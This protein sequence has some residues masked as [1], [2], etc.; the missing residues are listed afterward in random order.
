[1][2][3]LLARVK[4]TQPLRAWTRFGNVRGNLLASGIAFY[5]FF[6]IFPA[7]AIAAVIFGFVLRGHPE[8]IASVGHSLNQTLPNF[9]KTADNPD[10]L[11]ELKA[12]AVSALTI[13]GLVAV[14]GLVLSG[15]GWVG[16]MRDGIRAVFGVAGSPG[17]LITD[18]L[19]DLG[20]LVSLGAGVLVSG[21]L[22]SLLGSGA[23]GLSERVGLG[24]S[25]V[26]VTVVG[27]VVGF[28][29]DVAVMVL[30]LRVLS[31]VPLPWQDV[32]EGALV[33]GIGLSVIKIFGVQL[34]GNATK[35]PLFGSIV[36]VIGLLF[37][38]NLIAKIILLAASW[39]AN[40]IDEHLARLET[41]I[42]SSVTDDEVLEYQ[43][44]TQSSAGR[45]QSSAG[46]PE[47][48]AG[49]PRPGPGRAQ[50]VPG[51]A[52]RLTAAGG[53]AVPT[54]SGAAQR[55]GEVDLCDDRSRAVSGIPAFGPRT[56]D[57]ASIAAGA[58]LGATAAI[59]L[60]S[61]GRTIRS[62]LTRR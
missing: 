29:V 53:G 7:V 51:R 52:Q 12:P 21:V 41:S 9:I 10:G 20:V 22:T 14:V 59:A 42:G 44:R 47:P 56:Q 13:G 30:L 62:L 46:R 6:S 5:G 27:L 36:L 3:Q 55:D 50:S 4:Q 1:V 48:G 25:P 8:L 37:W 45:T 40:D 35:N 16:A 28:V 38:L 26:L 61:V 57:R 2:K 11:I 15:V 19:R 43:R 23:S 54:S 33:G 34:I 58:V 24:E 60:G 32:R 49:R 17:N 31:G 39:A 18:K